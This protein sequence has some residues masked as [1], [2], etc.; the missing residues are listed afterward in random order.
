MGTW[1]SHVLPLISLGFS[2]I[3]GSGCWTSEVKAVHIRHGGS[4]NGGKTSKLMM[5]HQNGQLL[6]KMW[7]NKS[8]DTVHVCVCT[9]P[10]A[11][12]PCQVFVD[13]DLLPKIACTSKQTTSGWIIDGNQNGIG[14]FINVG[15]P[16]WCFVG[17]KAWEWWYLRYRMFLCVA[18]KKCTLHKHPSIKNMVAGNEMGKCMHGIRCVSFMPWGSTRRGLKHFLCR[19]NNMFVITFKKNWREMLLKCTI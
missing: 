5:R 9:A 10:A 8:I 17:G 7:V 3:S 12:R 4:V 18:F 15:L 16:N 6:A 1:W 13:D 11:G 19:V 14:P 2:K